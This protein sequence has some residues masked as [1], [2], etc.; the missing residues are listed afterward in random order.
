MKIFI[1]F[2]IGD[3]N[4]GFTPSVGTNFAVDQQGNA[5]AQ[6]GGGVGIGAVNFGG[7]SNGFNPRPNA[8]GVRRP[9][10]F[11]FGRR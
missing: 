8:G 2:S 7:L 6:V 10:P 11:L 4:G 9:V 3:G 1:I 5:N